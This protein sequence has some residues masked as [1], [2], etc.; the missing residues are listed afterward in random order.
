MTQ[1]PAPIVFIADAIV[2]AVTAWIALCAI[3]QSRKGLLETSL[4]WPLLGL[5]WIVGSGALLGLCGG[6]SRAGFFLS[7][8]IGLTALLIFRREWREDWKKWIGWLADWW[9]LLRSATPVGVAIVALIL[10]VLFLAGLAARSEPSIFDALTY[11][12]PRIGQWLQDGRISIFQTDDPRLNYMPV[13][14]DLVITW[15]L[16]ATDHGFWLAPLSQLIGGVLLLAATFGLARVGGLGRQAALGA[17]V[18][19]LGMAN[20]SAQF[21]LIQSDLFT[22]GVF[23]A[24]YVLWQRA[25]MRDEGSWLGGIGVGLAWGSKGT[26]FYLAP[27]AALWVGWLIYRR[28]WSWPLL[29]PTVHG[30]ALALLIF[31]G[32]SYYRNFTEYRSIFGPREAMVLH[33]GGPLTFAQHLEKLKLNLETSAVQLFDPTAQP[34]WCQKLLRRVGF[35]LLPILP[36]EDDPYLFLH[37]TPRRYRIGSVLSQPAPDADVLSCGM[38]AIVFFCFGGLI[39]WVRRTRDSSAPQILVWGAGVVIYVLVQHALVQWHPWAFR[40]VVLAAPWMGVVAAWGVSRLARKVQ[41]ILWVVIATSSLQVF[42][43]VEAHL[44]EI[45]PAISKPN[46][47]FPLVLY[48]SWRDWAGQLGQPGKPLKLAFPINYAEGCFYRLPD[49]RPVSLERFSGLETKTAEEAINASDGWLVVPAY[50]FEG[51]EGRVAGKTFL[52]YGD[53]NSGY[54]VAAYRALAAGEK[55]SPILYHDSE[56]AITD[57]VRHLFR[58]KAWDST[59][60]LRV[61]NPSNVTWRFEVTAGRGKNQGQLHAGDEIVLQIPVETVEP[62]EVILDFHS[63]VPA[64]KSAAHPTAALMKP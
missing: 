49:A 50:A 41:L 62:V 53:E 5:A 16:G 35:E 2:V 13:G 38:L 59:V 24:S 20:V 28:G 19:V 1:T 64:Q 37:D 29:R 42:T 11:R 51:R 25:W 47:C 30:A 6:L 44:W 60:T 55:P 14:P 58:I 57:G 26:L 4:G 36:A 63:T 61:H 12:L 7:H 34:Y 15:L 46:S 21:T 22:A 9:R 8:V 33:H 52:L 40:F 23:A 56:S 32:P 10:I 18:L 43:T 54:S 27:G 45:S 31:V 48:R 17:V 3:G 39:A